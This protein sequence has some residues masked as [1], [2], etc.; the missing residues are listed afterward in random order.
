MFWLETGRGIW[1]LD[2]EKVL[3]RCSSI[4]LDDFGVVISVGLVLVDMKLFSMKEV[5][6]AFLLGF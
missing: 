3:G 2:S 4:T 6:L 5:I 1:A